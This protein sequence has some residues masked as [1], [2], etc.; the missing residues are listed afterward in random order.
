MNTRI[1]LAALLVLLFAGCVA[2]GVNID[3]S[4]W[5]ID[6]A[7]NDAAPTGPIKIYD[8]QNRLMLDGSLVAGKMDGTWTAW[9]SD[10]ERV[11]IW[12]YRNGLRH[13][14]IQMWYGRFAYPEAAGRLKLEGDFE[15][16][17]YE[18][19]VTRYHASGA[20]RSVRLY[21]QGVIKSAQCWGPDGTE[22]PPALTAE[23]AAEEH[24]GDMT[25]LENLEGMVPTSLAQA[26]RRIR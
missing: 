26:Q 8:S 15:D 12:H 10:G 11:V 18:G 7:S 17:H 21:E 24:K 6:V 16:G 13:G 25:Y 14:P 9:T 4:K 20:R 2:P 22:Q 3:A 23:V 1:C 19:K 5:V